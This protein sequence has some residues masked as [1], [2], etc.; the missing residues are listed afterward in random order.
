MSAVGAGIGAIA[1]LARAWRRDGRAERFLLV[2]A[3]TTVGAF[4]VGRTFW[5]QYLSHLVVAE[6][7]LA[8]YASSTAWQLLGRRPLHVLRPVLALALAATPIIPLRQSIQAGR[9]RTHELHA[10]ADL[11]AREVP[12]DDCLFA[13]EPAWALA[14]G[15]LPPA[16]D[17]PAIA[18]PYGSMLLPTSSPDLDFE[19]I[20]PAFEVPSSQLAVRRLLE[21]CDWVIYGGRGPAQLSE[22]SEAWFEANYERAA[23]VPGPAGLDLWRRVG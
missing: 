4:L 8:G 5:L 15:R 20:G 3:T 10:L 23:V 18:D 9:P 2:L 17:R 7:L 22:V 12:P 19:G 1:A 6:A 14:S 21:D 11:V 13:F 16:G